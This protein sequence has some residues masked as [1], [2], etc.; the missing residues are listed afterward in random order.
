MSTNHKV[1]PI[2]RLDASATRMNAAHHFDFLP[3][4][5]AN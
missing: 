3:V 2:V 1:C 4:I 5:H